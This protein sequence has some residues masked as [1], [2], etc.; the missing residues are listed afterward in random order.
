MQVADLGMFSSWGRLG[1]TALQPSLGSRSTMLSPAALILAEKKC[2]PARKLGCCSFMRSWRPEGLLSSVVDGVVV[3]A[4]VA[5]RWG[6][7]AL[8]G[9]SWK[10]SVAS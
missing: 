4:A 6:S 2:S 10:S 8:Y 1:S 7:Q 3:Y 5:I 9:Q